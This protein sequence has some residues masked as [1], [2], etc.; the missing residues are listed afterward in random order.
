MGIK[1]VSSRNASTPQSAHTD[2][3]GNR[4]EVNLL[5]QYSGE[6]RVNKLS[7]DVLK[8]RF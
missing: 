1:K 3:H 6:T 7:S 5:A 8:G 4:N 2:D